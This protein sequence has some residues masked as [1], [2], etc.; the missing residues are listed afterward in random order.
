M[1]RAEGES[2]PEAPQTK[3]G[4]SVPAMV[5]PYK[6]GVTGGALGGSAMVAV[7]LI[8]GVVS[9]RGIWLPV[10]LV[11]ATLIL[12]LQG[13]PL[14]KLAEFN[15]AALIV[16]VI[17]HATISIGIG[18]VF[19]VLLPTLPGPPVIWSLTVGSLLWALAS[20]LILPALNPTMAE[21]VDVP[22]FLI[23]HLV[24][25]IVLGWWIPRTPKIRAE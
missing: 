9:G 16:G 6:V 7:A 10:N 4:H 23:A 19:A 11:G 13:A 24:Y 18:F 21:H 12:D 20:L 25:G 5:Y 17:L 22:S 8:Y 15:A 2:P 1:S 3:A 14:E